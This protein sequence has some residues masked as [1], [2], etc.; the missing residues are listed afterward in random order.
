MDLLS[1]FD[2]LKEDAIMVRKLVVSLLLLIFVLPLTAQNSYRFQQVTVEDGLANN[3]IQNITEDKFGRI[4]FATY[5]GLSLFDGFEYKIVRPF[6]SGSENETSVGCANIITV[7]SI[8]NIWVLLENSTLVRLINDNGE[9]IFYK[10]LAVDKSSKNTIGLD[11][12]GNIYYQ[13][14][15]TYYSFD[16]IRSDFKRVQKIDIPQFFPVEEITKQLKFLF[17]RVEI[18]SIYRSPK[19]NDIWILTLNKGIFYCK[20]GDVSHLINYGMS[21]P[22]PHKISSNEVY[23]I[24]EDRSG[25]IWIGTKNSGIN[26]AFSKVDEFKTFNVIGSDNPDLQTTIRAIYQEKNSKLWIGTYNNGIVI[27]QGEKIERIHLATQGKLDK[28]DW[29]RSIYQ[30]KDQYIWV[31]TYVG[32]CRIHP[33][34]KEIKYWPVGRNKNLPSLGRIY[35]I[36]EDQKGNLYLG[37][38][39]G[40]DYYD[41]EKNQFICFDTLDE[42]KNIHIRKLHLCTSGD[43]WIGTEA[44]GIFVLDTKTH[45]IKKHIT[46]GDAE[47]NSILSNSIFDIY[48]DSA[49]TIWVASFGGLNA[50]D[51]KWNVK[52]FA[53]L[54]KDLP[55]SLIYHVFEDAKHNLWCGSP[56]GII[57]VNLQS[58]QVRVYD[59]KD[60]GNISEFAEGAAFKNQDGIL[61]FGGYNNIVSFHPDSIH[62]S[63]EI[64]IPMLKSV[65]VN[66][67]SCAEFAYGKVCDSCFVFP[68]WKDKISFSLKGI[69]LSSPNKIK[70]AWILKSF[71]Q[72]YQ[73]FQGPVH[74]ISYSDLPH[75]E[76]Q[77]WIKTANAD[78]IWSDEKKMFSF[79]IEKPFW[80]EFYFIVSLIFFLAI[81]ILTVVRIRFLQVRRKNKKLED[82]VI[83]RTLKIENQK[84][85]LQQVNQSLE[86]KNAKVSE[87]RD[88]ILAQRDHLFEMHNRLEELN[89][90]KQNFFTNISHDIRTPL[91]L[92]ISPL[93]ELLQ[94]KN[95]SLEM[96]TKLQ[97][98]QT[99]SNYILQLIEQVLDKRKL[100]V[101]GLHLIFKQGDI[102]SIIKTVIN[103]FMNQME[104]NLLKLTFLTSH[105]SFYCRYDYDKLQQIVFNLLTNAI[106]F[107]PAGGQITCEL[108]LKTKGFEFSVTD[109]GIGIPSDRIKYIFDRYYQVGKSSQPEN[110]GVGIGLSLVNDFVHLLKGRIQVESEEGSGSKFILFL[111]FHSAKGPEDINYALNQEVSPVEKEF[112]ANIDMD[113]SRKELILL[114]EDNFDL[115]EY[116]TEVLSEKYRVVTVANGSEALKYLKKDASVNLILSDWVMPE[117]D[118]IQLCQNLK[119]KGRYRGIP[120]VLL[121]ALSEIENQK[122]AY[123]SGIDD[124]I[125]KPFQIELLFL[126]ISNLLQRNKQIKV[127]ANTDAVMK[128]ENK[129]VETYDEKLFAKLKEMMEKEISNAKFGQTELAKEMGM[130]QMQLY[131]KLKEF[132]SMSP[133]EFIRS[134]RIKRSLQLLE[135]EGITI[136]E[137]S[138]MVGFNDPKYFSRCFA[139]QQGMTPSKYRNIHLSNKK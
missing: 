93:S 133:N 20:D 96:R 41:R 4:W 60:I 104:S 112:L 107:T 12:N 63:A 27:K 57:H 113:E 24:F 106:K 34:T 89:R 79:K 131:R 31:G 43:L 97:C 92:I 10:D 66:G 13:S 111:P 44:Q 100:E 76:Y 82:I 28:W 121:T 127:A 109:T 69:Q 84:E 73:T 114:V 50:I 8:G 46:K 126:K 6:E 70:L 98:M 132:T 101:G 103:S 90:L 22:D 21:V 72:N 2:Q 87:Q 59:Q 48:E 64:P 17:P 16:S 23:C 19:G 1:F 117:M 62:S 15:N 33:E 56:K 5:D 129:M 94:N 47:N 40:L 105:E 130:S 18:Y 137:V 128:P 110:E 81:C 74:E 42:L 78:G 54:N 29:V 83:K 26:V 36:A 68:F 86:E 123:Y 65:C 122:E 49:G 37:E 45:R 77:L 91:T 38:W 88:Q 124:F 99:N 120:F 80:L 58:E 125:P 116:L 11:S 7:D 119:K 32:I 136:N 55:S 67:E 51:G 118:G 138:D 61:F 35:S 71:D 139:K 9:S 52:E 102:V 135:R 134:F 85:K 75:G 53:Y 3:T 115:R 25:N 39:G 95:L 30:S 108:I 14:G